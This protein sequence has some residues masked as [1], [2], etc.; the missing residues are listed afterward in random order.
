[1]PPFAWRDVPAPIEQVARDLL[2]TAL[3]RVQ[4]CTAERCRNLTNGALGKPEYL[5]R[6]GSVALRNFHQKPLLS[7][8]WKPL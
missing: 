6:E 2:G 3:D 5:A 4:R 1:M 8:K 7:V